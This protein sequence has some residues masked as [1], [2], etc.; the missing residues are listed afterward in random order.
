MNESTNNIVS[1][2]I[3]LSPQQTGTVG[4]FPIYVFPGLVMPTIEDIFR[5]KTEELEAERELPVDDKTILELGKKYFEANKKELLKKYQNKY[6]AIL[7]N[8][9]VGSDKDFS[10]LAER[11]YKKFGYQTIY[12]PF[13]SEQKRTVKIPSPKI[14]NL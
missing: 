9:V 8:K 10:R 1:E 7:N 6:I 13:V 11:T 12:M 3:I 14:G 2:N 4:S 5:K